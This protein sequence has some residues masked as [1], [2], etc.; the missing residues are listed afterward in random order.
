MEDE[1]K[2]ETIRSQ[3]NR[4]THTAVPCDEVQLSLENLNNILC[5]LFSE[6]NNLVGET[7]Q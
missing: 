6:G 7:R 1:N 3:K 2:R 4:A 5:G